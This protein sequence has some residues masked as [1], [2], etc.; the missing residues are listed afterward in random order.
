MGPFGLLI[1]LWLPLIIATAFLLLLQLPCTAFAVTLGGILPDQIRATAVATLVH[2]WLVASV[3]FLISV[4]FKSTQQAVLTS[5]VIF[6]IWFAGSNLAKSAAMRIWPYSSF[7]WDVLFD[8]ADSFSG[9]S[10]L[11]RIRSTATPALWGFDQTCQ[12]MAAIV[13]LVVGGLNLERQSS[14]GP[15]ATKLRHRQ[16]HPYRWHQ[17]LAAIFEKDFR[18]AG[19]GWRWVAIRAIVYPLA[20]F[21][22]VA[23]ISAPSGWITSAMLHETALRMAGWDT[24][25]VLTQLFQREV[26]EQTWGSL[27]I[28]PFSICQISYVKLAGALL[29][30]SPGWIWTTY[31]SI[32]LASFGFPGAG[33]LEIVYFANIAIFGCHTAVLA[34]V[35]IPR[36]TWTIPMLLGIVAA[37]L[38]LEFYRNCSFAIG[39]G[40]AYH[41]FVWT[42]LAVSLCITA[43]LHFLIVR[44]IHCLS[45]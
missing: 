39:A 25:M 12:M 5:F 2:L 44:R 20:G 43:F 29:A 22:Y 13:A 4:Y 8:W 10:S 36:V 33:L 41:L 35:L 9:F 3:G 37:H 16:H 7:D 45:D 14:A 31:T 27:K 11:S 6:G 23:A 17:G 21:A 32:H 42:M 28:L 30:V 1:A 40:I 38:Q 15:P 18:L 19:G 24:A 26:R 34:S